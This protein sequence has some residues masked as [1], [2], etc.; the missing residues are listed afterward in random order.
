MKISLRWKMIACF[1]L[2]SIVPFFLSLSVFIYNT[3]NRNKENLFE[4]IDIRS[5]QNAD[6]ISEILIDVDRMFTTL[7]RNADLREFL[8]SQYGGN[9]ADALFAYQS[10][11]IQTQIDNIARDYT[12]RLYNA[13][14]VVGIAPLTNND[15]DTFL[16]KYGA[17]AA[18]AST[19]IQ[20]QY[21]EAY[22]TQPARIGFY[23]VYLESAA[24]PI[25]TTIEVPVA[26]LLPNI[27]M[28]Y[29]LL[30][31]NTTP[32][33]YSN[34][35]IFSAMLLTDEDFLRIDQKGVLSIGDSTYLAT[36]H[37]ISSLLDSHAFRNEIS[38]MCL[39]PYDAFEQTLRESLLGIV[40]LC[41]F[42]VI[43]SLMVTIIFTRRLTTRIGTMQEKTKRVLNLDFNIAEPV[44]IQ[45][46]LGDLEK[47]IYD[48][49]SALAVQIEREYEA[50]Q[51]EGEQRLLNEK[52]H[53]AWVKAQIS[54][55]RHQINPHYLF[56]TLESI[57]MHL[58]LKGDKE[59]AKILQMFADSYRKSLDID[60]GDYTLK[61][62]LETINDFLVIQKYRLGD[63][64]V[65]H[66]DVDDNALDC[67]LPK[68]IL[69][70]LVENAFFHGIELS[71][72]LGQLD[73]HIRRNQNVVSIM[74][75]DNGLGIA[76]EKLDELK[77]DLKKK[78]SSSGTGIG[79]RNIANR[80]HLLYGS[81][82]LFDIESQYG[83]GTTITFEIPYRK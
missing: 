21:L 49:A 72:R 7:I 79:I 62:E 1:L 33:I 56:N 39:F 50:I 59:S 71:N 74:V 82:T 53:N 3:S 46:E 66:I 44:V 63:R 34:A 14:P 37:P 25:Y 11:A 32:I 60:Y 51:A 54:S 64:F 9:Q 4:T 2:A 38:L 81:E 17:D 45:D 10:M 76:N 36:I 35:E 6:S 12:V 57:R 31:D 29:A 65:S 18:N 22:G 42:C 77:E 47:D 78:D 41:L 70:P 55:L 28:E 20:I 30:L 68:L 26:D 15:L 23:R 16:R 75:R 58:L 8:Y 24:N 61:D 40:P 80:L 5:S 43:F 13:D 67:K 48:M 73:I 83:S 27:D 19:K 69:Q 52:L